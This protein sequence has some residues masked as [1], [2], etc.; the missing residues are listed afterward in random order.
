MANEIQLIH[1]D[2]AETVYAIVRDTAGNWYHGTNPEAFDDANWGDYD[3]ALAE[4]HAAASGNVAVQATF[5]AVAAGFY[6]LDVYVQAG[7]NPAQT[8]FRVSSCLM[9]WNATTLVPAGGA[10]DVRQIYGTDLAAAK[11][12]ATLAAADCTD[13]YL[14]GEGYSV[15]DWHV[16]PTLGS[17]INDGH[18]WAKAKQTI[19]ATIAAMSNYDSLH[20]RGQINEGVDLNF[21]GLTG[22]RIIGYRGDLFCA[23]A[24]T[25]TLPNESHV[26]GL[27]IGGISGAIIALGNGNTFVQ[28]CEV[29]GTFTGSAW[30]L[31][32]NCV[33]A[34][35]TNST[36]N[37]VIG[38]GC[39]VSAV[40]SA[41]RYSTDVESRA[42]EA[43]VGAIA[44]ILSGITSL[45]HW[46]RGLYNKRAMNSE[47]LTEIQN[48]TGTFDPTT[49]SNEAI[50]D[51]TSG[52]TAQQTRDAMKLA[53]SNGAPIAGSIDA[54]LD[55]ISGG[56]GAI[57]DTILVTD[58][59][60]F[61]VDS[62]DVWITNDV[63]GTDGGVKIAGSAYTDDNGRATFSLD[64]GNYW[65]HVQKSGLDF[66]ATYPKKL[67]V[68]GGIFSWA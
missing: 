5:P 9:Y 37:V 28:D 14:P 51:K 60:D 25:I 33:L 7:A 55:I 11:V 4:V 41:I 64:N 31:F 29:Y 57:T 18:S 27:Y 45:A 13:G 30:V 49:D 6:W 21:G 36:P 35:V 50:A 54:E 43:S 52:L 53:P 24:Q 16:D 61:P 44:T 56:G 38:P 46:L 34:A 12:P 39:H 17:D 1:D 66:T 58:P 47:A 22:I 62:A 40:G 20:I 67:T 19:A 3:I 26:S 68:A 48:I 23:G 63:D 65:V 10:A 59:S 8:D 15:L 32:T 2:G 42:K